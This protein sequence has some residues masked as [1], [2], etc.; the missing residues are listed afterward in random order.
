MS[1]MRTLNDLFVQKLKYVYDA[2]AE[3]RLTKALPK[4]SKA[5]RTPELKEAFDTHLRETEIHVDRIE[6]LFGMFGSKPDADT[7]DSMKGI[8]SAGDDVAGW[9]G[10]DSVRDA[11]LIAA[12][13]EAEHWEIAA[14]GTLRTWA[15]VL[16]KPEAAQLLAFTLDEEKNADNTLTQIAQRLNF[17]AA[18]PQVR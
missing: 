16:G 12:A 8:V 3:Q 2:D 14:Y 18:A 7:S 11:G 15:Q 9:K 10:D 5:A 6:N 17:R 4:L 1:E 13:Q